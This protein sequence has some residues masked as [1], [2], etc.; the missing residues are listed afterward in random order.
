[1]SFQKDMGLCVRSKNYGIMSAFEIY[2]SM[3]AFKQTEN[4]QKIL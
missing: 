2:G 4:M 1:M 3:C